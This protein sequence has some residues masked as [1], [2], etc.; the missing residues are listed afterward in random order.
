M[1][2]NNIYMDD[3][4][5]LFNLRN[6]NRDND[7]RVIHTINLTDTLK[8]DFSFELFIHHIPTTSNPTQYFQA[9]GPGGGIIIAF[10]KGTGNN[11]MNISWQWQDSGSARLISTSIPLNEWSHWIFT[12]KQGGSVR[13]YKNGTQAA[14]NSS[15]NTLN[16]INP[17]GGNYVDIAAFCNHTVNGQGGNVRAFSGFF[18]HFRIF[19]KEFDSSEVST[20]YNQRYEKL[21]FINNVVYSMSAKSRN[22][23]FLFNDKTRRFDIKIDFLKKIDA[24]PN[25]NA[26]LLTN[27]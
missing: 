17:N 21:E 16:F 11:N 24:T 18:K 6:I 23:E 13:I 3:E 25:G 12:F 4:F 8:S 1:I 9:L 5:G 14:I 10:G 20:L 26:W 2:K 22:G 27:P 19:N 7:P 15:G